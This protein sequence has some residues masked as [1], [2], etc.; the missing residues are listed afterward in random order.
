[1][2]VGALWLCT[3]GYTFVQ[4]FDRYLA[5]N[6]TDCATCSLLERVKEDNQWELAHNETQNHFMAP[7]PG[8]PGWAGAR[9]NLLLD[10]MMPRKI[11][12]ADTPTIRLGATPS[13][14][15]S[16]PLPSSPNFYARCPSGRNPFTLSWLGTSTK[17]AGLHTQWLGLYT[18]QMT[19]CELC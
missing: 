16:G 19:K 14:L 4:Y 10:F 2:V 18:L 15:I 13:G 9:R 11:T 1:M 3:I 8:L 12:E 6:K 5:Y 17:Y 7:F